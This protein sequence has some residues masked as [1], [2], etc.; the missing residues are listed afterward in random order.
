[1]SDNNNKDTIFVKHENKFYPIKKRDINWIYAKGDFCRIN[2]N[3]VPTEFTLRTSL[4]KIK[5]GL[6][7]EMFFQPH[8]NYIINLNKI[9]LYDPIGAVQINNQEIPVSKKYKK[10]LEEKLNFLL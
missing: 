9:E 1:M 3:G 4:T 10:D 7:R 2:T 6:C 8:R 5:V